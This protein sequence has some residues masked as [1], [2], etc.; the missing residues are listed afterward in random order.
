MS[1]EVITAKAQHEDTIDLGKAALP[2][3]ENLT[4]EQVKPYFNNPRR[5][6]EE[7]V[8]AVRTSIENYGYVQPIVVDEDYTIIVGHTRYEALKQLGQ[9][10]VDVYVAE[11]LDERKVKQ[12]R[13]VD[14]KTSELSDWNHEKLVLELREWESDLLDTYFPNVDLEVGQLATARD[15]NDDDVAR[16]EERVK[17]VGMGQEL[18]APLTEVHCP[19]CFG[20]FDVK[21]DTMPGLSD[22][23]ISKL[24]AKASMDAASAE[25][26]DDTEADE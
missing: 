1:Q 20:T 21:A 12:Y 26:Q 10:H 4:I 5:I 14:N 6:P 23:D 25:D 17:Q 16:A 2:E 19:S 15:Y 24:K 9:T 22:D 18:N 3:P 8:D 7:A 11:D 13:L